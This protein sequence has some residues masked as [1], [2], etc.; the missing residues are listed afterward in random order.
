[1]CTQLKGGLLADDPEVAA[2][3]LTQWQALR[4]AGTAHPRR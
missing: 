4:D 2:A 1:M 3:Y